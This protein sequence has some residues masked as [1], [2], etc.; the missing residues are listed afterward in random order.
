MTTQPTS[1]YS[2]TSQYTTP[3]PF[4]K[5]NQPQFPGTTYLSLI[6]HGSKGKRKNTI[7]DLTCCIYAKHI[8]FCA[9]D[10]VSSCYF[11]HEAYALEDRR[12]GCVELLHFIDF[13]LDCY[14]VFGLFI[15]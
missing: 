2:E 1:N 6:P 3:C 7:D 4:E 11:A 14:D 13:R 15:V 9:C 12:L 10:L 8:F 5:S